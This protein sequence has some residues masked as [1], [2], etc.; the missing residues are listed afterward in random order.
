MNAESL[1]NRNAA[2]MAAAVRN[3]AVSASAL[4]QASLARIG[5][6]EPRVNA[7]TD[8]TAQRALRTATPAR[9]PCPCSAFR[10]R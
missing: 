5:A 7:F 8:V 1:L 4:V 3:G 9:R 6:T 10:S 2:E